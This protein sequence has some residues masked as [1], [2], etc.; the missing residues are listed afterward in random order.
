MSLQKSNIAPNI[1]YDN[2]I[3]YEWKKNN[4]VPQEHSRWD[5]F[6]E[7]SEKVEEQLRKICEQEAQKSPENAIG[8]YYKIA[9]ENK[10]VINGPESILYLVL[11][12][13]DLL[14][15]REDIISF[16]GILYSKWGV[17]S[18]FTIDKEIDG[19]NPTQFVPHFYQSGISLPDRDYYFDNK[20]TQKTYIQYIEKLMRLFGYKVSGQKVFQ[21]ERQFAGMHFIR[22]RTRDPFLLYNKLSFRKLKDILGSKWAG[23]FYNLD[24]PAHM[25]SVIVDCE[26][27]YKHINTIL[28]RT[29]ITTLKNWLRYLLVKH[30]AR[31]DNGDVLEL[32]FDFW[33]KYL[34]GNQKIKKLWKRAVG[35]VN[36]FLGEE[37]GKLYVKDYFDDNLKKLCMEMI[38]KIRYELQ[39]KIEYNDWMTPDTKEKA[40]DKLKSFKF[41]VGYPTHWSISIKDL[42]WK[43]KEN[44]ITI[45]QAWSEWNWAYEVSGKFY[46]L[47]IDRWLMTPQTVNAYYCSLTNS[48]AIPAAILQP[49][50]FSQKYDIFQN[51]GGIGGVIAHE[52]THAFDDQGKNYDAHGKLRVWWNSK[53]NKQ[54]DEKAEQIEKRY[55]RLKYCGKNINGKLTL[56]ENIADI[57][58]AKIAIAV[59]DS[60]CDQLDIPKTQRRAIYNKFFR[61]WAIVWRCNIHK[62]KALENLI[63]DPHSPPHERINEPLKHLEQFNITYDVQPNDPMYLPIEERMSIW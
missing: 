48:I 6:E 41:K 59:V 17:T 4:P 7:L 32:S 37:L 36:D 52:M 3:N 35:W 55:N 33:N 19:K 1:D 21:L 47:D 10:T 29:S 43:C 28:E 16:S 2:Y 62:E 54:Y 38:Y 25:G 18:C 39:R 15:T 31:F 40:I 58:G 22:S 61:Q 45:V 34:Q 50:F 30:Y 5:S 63:V 53:D 13:I 57:G 8:H 46:S 42:Q 49:P 51:L 11:R 14:K 44:M 24:L 27:F 23:F 20:D 56:G 26:N 9:M 12:Q 60:I